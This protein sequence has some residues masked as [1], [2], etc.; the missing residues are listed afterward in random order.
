MAHLSL[1]LLGR[2][3]ITLDGEPAS[4]FD[5]NKVRALL[6]YLAVESD[7]SHRRESLAALLWPESPAR[8]AR[9]NLRNALANLRKVLRHDDP[10]QPIIL[11]TRD[12]LQFNQESNAYIDV[13][14]FNALVN[15][16]NPSFQQ[17]EKAV[18]QTLIAVIA[19][20]VRIAIVVRIVIVVRTAIKTMTE[21]SAI[22]K[23]LN[24]TIKRKT[25]QKTTFWLMLQTRT[26]LVSSLMPREKKRT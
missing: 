3:T 8:S 4:G 21:K 24:K 16:E 15:I 23:I 20:A 10:D 18:A 26:L 1:N 12:T 11:V 9:T 22:A 2:F 14:A 19:T 5:S 17:L 13:T 7:R 25:I 6:A